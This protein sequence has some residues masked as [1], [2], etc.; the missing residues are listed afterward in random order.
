[1][2]PKFLPENA[3]RLSG[4]GA[5]LGPAG[6]I[7]PLFPICQKHRRNFPDPLPAQQPSPTRWF[8]VVSASFSLFFLF[9]CVPT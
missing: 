5:G 6:S 9:M 8:T 2:K 7:G 4:G 1:M 3:A